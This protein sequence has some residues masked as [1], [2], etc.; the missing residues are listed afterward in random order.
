MK[1]ALARVVIFG[2]FQVSS[3]VGNLCYVYDV[4]SCCGDGGL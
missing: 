4:V 1:T 3:T 2:L